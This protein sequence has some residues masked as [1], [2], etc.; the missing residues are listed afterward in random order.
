MVDGRRQRIAE[1]LRQH[2]VANAVP[3]PHAERLGGLFLTCRQGLHAAAD[4]LGLIAGKEERVA[5][6][7]AVE[8]VSGQPVRQHEG[9]NDRKG[10]HD[11]QQRQR[12]DGI[13]DDAHG[14]GDHRQFRATQERE[15]D[16]QR[17]AQQGRCRK[18]EDRQRQPAPVL[19]KDRCQAE[20]AATHQDIEGC[21][22]CQPKCGDPFSVPEIRHTGQAAHQN[23]RQTG[24]SRPPLFLIWIE[25]KE[26]QTPAAVDH[27]P[28]GSTRAMGTEVTVFRG[29]HSVHDAP[30]DEVINHPQSQR[31]KDGGHRRV[32]AGREVIGADAVDQGWFYVSLCHD[33]RSAT[34]CL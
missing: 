14:L 21:E 8:L 34:D 5:D 24:Q 11:R 23:N 12:A 13:D 15:D 28:A 32:H 4:D 2:D 20:I 9:Q 17:H 19:F 16:R 25:T 26:D 29:P 6:N 3:V 1:G 31:T 33:L 18:D 30:A 27:A 22:T 7:D 10:E